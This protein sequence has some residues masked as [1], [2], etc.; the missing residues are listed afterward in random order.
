M[1]VFINLV[2]LSGS[3]IIALSTDD[4]YEILKRF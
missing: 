3:A 1:M 2:I 4:Q